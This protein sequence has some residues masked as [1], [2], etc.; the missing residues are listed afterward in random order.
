MRRSREIYLCIA[1]RKLSGGKLFLYCDANANGEIFHFFLSVIVA[2]WE[3]DLYDDLCF[4]LYVEQ[5][6]GTD[7]GGW[8]EGVKWSV[9]FEYD[10]TF[11]K[12]K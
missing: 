1:Y 9:K 4:E 8:N 6:M 5:R 7:W 2:V 12:Y 10:C 11:L 3:I